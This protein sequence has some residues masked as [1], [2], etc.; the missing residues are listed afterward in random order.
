[1]K[2]ERRVGIWQKPRLPSDYRRESRRE[3]PYDV[4]PQPAYNSAHMPCSVCL[5]VESVRGVVGGVSSMLMP[6]DVL[7]RKVGLMGLR[8][9][10][11]LHDATLVGL[12]LDR[13]GHA[14]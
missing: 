11:K 7:A 13:L 14:R 2:R 4:R 10:D 3:T 9:S 12:A 5:N 1:M 6:V 8:P